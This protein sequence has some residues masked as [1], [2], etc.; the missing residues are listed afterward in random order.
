MSDGDG[1]TCT[2]GHANAG[3]VRFCIACGAAARYCIEC[4]TRIPP[5]QSFCTGCGTLVEPSAAA[6]AAA[7]PAITTAAAAQDERRAAREPP[8]TDDVPPWSRPAAAPNAPPPAAGRSRDLRVPLAAA[9]LLLVGGGVAY[10]VFGR[11]N[12]AASSLPRTTVDTIVAAPQLAVPETVVSTVVETVEAEP[13]IATVT[14][15]PPPATASDPG[16]AVAPATVAT[17]AEPP[18]P[19][20]PAAAPA[21]Q[22]VRVPLIR[23]ML[24]PGPPS[25]CVS[26][27]HRDQPGSMRLVLRFRSG[28]TLSYAS[29]NAG[30]TSSRWMFCGGSTSLRLPGF[31]SGDLRFSDPTGVARLVA[32]SGVI[33]GDFD[34]PLRRRVSLAIEYDGTPRCRLHTDALGHAVRFRCARFPPQSSPSHVTLALR[35]AGD[36][37]ARRVRRRRRARRRRRPQLN[38]RIDLARHLP[39]L[40]RLRRDRRAL[41]RFLRH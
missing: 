25:R 41:L 5:G 2:C 34:S 17:A 39:H 30:Q 20:T 24:M 10:A 35:V 31:A 29:R 38:E 15:A 6:G 27:L 26:P 40:R 1:W 14:V 12:D 23:D 16:L 18:V 37:R 32:V 22:R 13:T 3:N 19:A 33:G 7:P 8:A 4:G 21:A 36:R 11:G 9:G 28:R